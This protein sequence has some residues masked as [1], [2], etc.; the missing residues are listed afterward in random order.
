MIGGGGG[1][2][3]G[4]VNH[5]ESPTE[6][7]KYYRGHFGTGTVVS[8]S[9]SCSTSRHEGAEPTE[10]NYYSSTNDESGAYYSIPNDPLYGT[11]GTETTV[12]D[13]VQNPISFYSIGALRSE[14]SRLSSAEG[15][16]ASYGHSHFFGRMNGSNA[17]LPSASKGLRAVGSENYLAP[18]P[19]QQE[20]YLMPASSSGYRNALYDMANSALDYNVYSQAGDSN[21]DHAA[22]QASIAATISGDARATIESTGLNAGQVLIGTIHSSEHYYTAPSIATAH[23]RARL[24]PE[25]DASLKEEFYSIASNGEDLGGG[26]GAGYLDVHDEHGF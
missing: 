22:S 9:R 5:Y 7:G 26:F 11:G 25:S 8:V 24:D 4:Y 17:L 13:D 6:T 18:T 15:L 12:D 3:A 19:T 16:L 1:S 10:G 23:G 21:Y 20:T 14:S 2:S